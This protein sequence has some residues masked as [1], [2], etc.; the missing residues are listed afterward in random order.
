MIELTGEFLHR[1]EMIMKRAILSFSLLLVIVAALQSLNT[2]A[3]WDPAGEKLYELKYQMAEG[4]RFVMSSTGTME[5][6][7]DQMGTEV[8]AEITSEGEDTYS[9]QSSDKEKGLTIELVMGT[10]TQDVYSDQGSAS[11]DFSE[12][13]GKKVRFVLSFGGDV[14]G[15]EGFDALPEITAVTGE[16]LTPELYRLGVQETFTELPDKPVKIGDTWSEVEGNDI[17]LGGG[18]LRSESDFTYTVME[19]TEK[20][21]FDCLRIVFSGY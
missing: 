14:S 21:G 4:T 1:G 18:T 2:S 3:G 11:T 5:S 17:P 19:E 16:V 9:V 13:T 7:T 20:D 8:T 6:V 15:H 12:L 10:R